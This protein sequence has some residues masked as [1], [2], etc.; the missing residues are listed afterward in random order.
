MRSVCIRG[1]NQQFSRLIM[2]VEAGET[3]VITRQGKPMA[4]LTFRPANRLG[5]PE[6]RA[7]PE[8]LRSCLGE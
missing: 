1:A 7:K 6:V 5:D 3:V 8:R 2:D 4:Q